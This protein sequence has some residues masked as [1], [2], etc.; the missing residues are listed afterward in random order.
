LLYFPYEP[1]NIIVIHSGLKTRYS[2][3]EMTE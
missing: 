1:R 3:P 2:S